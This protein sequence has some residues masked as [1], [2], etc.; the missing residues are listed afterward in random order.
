MG[1]QFSSKQFSTFSGCLQLTYIT[2][3]IRK[4]VTSKTFFLIQRT[5]RPNIDQHI[6]NA[7]SSKVETM[8]NYLKNYSNKIQHFRGLP[9]W[10]R[11]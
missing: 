8:T 5:T 2:M 9:W 1:F 11:G 6:K 3:I 7:F 4:K 10:R